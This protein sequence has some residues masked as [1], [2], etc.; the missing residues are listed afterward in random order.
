MK[1]ILLSFACARLSLRHFG[2]Q[3]VRMVVL[4]T[5][6]LAVN[7]VA[8]DV[9]ATVAHRDLRPLAG[10]TLQLAG[11]VNVQGVTEDNG[12]V[13][14]LA[15]PPAGTVTI[16][17]S[18]SGFRFEPAQLTIPDLANPAAAAFSAVP[19]ATDLALSMTSDNDTPLV[20]GLV[21]AVITLRNLGTEAA[22]DVT[23]GF[24][25]LPG[26]A[27]EDAQATQGGLQFQA[28]GTQWKLPQLDPGASAEV[29]ARY[30]A[31]LPDAAVLAVA[32][33]QEMDQTDTAALNNSA[34][35]TTHTRAAQAQ[36][37]LA[38][39]LDPA[40]PK[41][42]QTLPVRLTIRNDGTNDATQVVIRSYLP[43]GAAFAA[44]TN[45]PPLD[46][47][48]VI[49]RLPAGA[50][51]EFSGPL[52]VR[53]A[54]T[55]TFIANVTY[56]EQQLPTGAAWPEARSDFTVQPAFS[57][58][59]LLAFTDPPNPRVGDD[60]TV[61]Y[62]AGNDGP[63]TVT[64]FQW[65]IREDPRLGDARFSDPVPAPPPVPG[66][67]VFSDVLPAGAYT[68]A[69]YHYSVQAAGDLTNYF[70]VA[71]QD[72]L[73]PN[74][75]DYPELF[76]PIKTLPADVG[77]SLD[78]NPKD[79][80]VTVGDPVTIEFPVHNDGPQPARGV[81]VHYSPQGLNP[82]EADEVIHA[83]HVVNP[84]VAGYID[85]V[86]AGETVT[87]R[88]HFVAS[89]PGVYTNIAEIEGSGERPDLLLPI[90]GETIRV[91]VLPGA[92][93]DLGI[94]VSLDKPQVNVGEYAL[95]IVTVTNR[96]AQPAVNVTVRETDAPDTRFAFEAVRNYG[97]LGD[98]RFG[99]GGLRTIPRIE[100]GASYSM[101]RTMRL[102]KPVI[103]PYLAKISGVSGLQE[104]DLPDWRATTQVTGVQVAS[105]IAPAVV[106]DRTNVK[107]G[108]LVN[109]AIIT[110]NGSAHVTSH[111]GINTGESAGFQVLPLGLGDYGYF[112]D[113]SRP[114]NLQ[115]SAKLFSEWTEIPAQ[116]AIF[117]SLSA[118]TVGTG[119]LTVGAQSVYLDQLDAQPTNDLA[120]IQIN[121]APASANVSLH[122]STFPPNPHVGD[123]V[124]FLTEIRNEGPDRVTGLSLLESSSTNLELNLNGDL[125]GISGYFVTSFLDSLVRL[126]ALEPGQNFVWQRTYSAR[127]AGSASR[128]VSVAR[129]DQTALGPLADNEATITVQ[130]AQADLALQFLVAPTVAQAN[131]PTLVAVRARNL[132]P[133]VA[134][135]VKV[136]IIVPWDTVSLGLFQLGPRTAYDFVASNVFRTALRPGESATASFYLKPSLVGSFTGFVQVQQSDQTDPNP[137]NDS[138][139]FTVNVGPE[140]PIPPIL[141]VRKVRTDFFDHTPIAEVEIDQAA[142]NRFAPFSLLSLE[143]SSNLR[144]WEW[145]TYTSLT[146]LAPVTFTDHAKPGEAMRAF[147]LGD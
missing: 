14:F 12:R 121:S 94:S 108:D 138:L 71:Y 104:S 115:S 10:V 67:F 116:E 53:F 147:R 84:P 22:T 38:M 6:G 31:T 21:N 83:D 15:L 89:T 76:V 87:L 88:K 61:I 43:P 103:I 33:I 124:L 2:L 100:P 46:S 9:T 18:R 91:H 131:I 132:G 36:L 146:S 112:W 119:Q 109:F 98:D 99:T 129:F 50:H 62:V 55:F 125:N 140:P 101:S 8:S 122:Q 58:L 90:A 20:G 133:A 25:A 75:A 77:L 102:R 5:A 93:P 19:T 32:V 82:A 130:P 13:T 7:V 143:G 1:A 35:L 142:L 126:P 69:V 85:E 59:T 134:T 56:F 48:V 68:Y 79:I 37:S 24:G 120:L 40:T 70:T 92:P 47:K 27:L 95:F 135:G 136:A 41:A 39:T 49:P 16:T 34:Q 106:P 78:A 128:R 28:V 17:P 74:A 30:R 144:D 97:P 72:Q 66:P 141:R 42:G 51:V 63:D 113:T 64:A 145:L 114:T 11:A 81:L 139:S 117:S 52:F 57:H 60:V 118:Y 137:A 123:F 73:I 86:G 110:P 45:Q 23:V 111:V 105:D 96:S 4:I 65:F 80:T 107:N 3:R 29:H 127:V 54:G 44:S 26:L